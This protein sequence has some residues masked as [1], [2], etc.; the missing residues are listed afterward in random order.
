MEHL[1]G[2]QSSD[3]TC[4]SIISCDPLFGT[5]A[6]NYRPQT[7]FE[8]RLSFYTCL[9]FCSRGGGGVEYLGRYPRV[10]IPP[11]RYTPRQVHPP[12]RYTPWQ[13]HPPGTRYP[14]PQTRY[15]ARPVHAG[16]YGQQAGGIHPTGMHACYD[17]MPG[18]Q[19]VHSICIQPVVFF[20]EL[21]FN[22]TKL[23]MLTLRL[24]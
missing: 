19:V 4:T 22:Y 8:A 18:K 23:A 10:G 24:T 7:K 21:S 14:T 15:T 11:G 5:D 20:I 13:V 3:S 9:W 12:G 6:H 17:L 2:Q 16:R 1:R